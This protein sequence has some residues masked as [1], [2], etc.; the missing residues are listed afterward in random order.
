MRGS[1]GE[2]PSSSG[3]F[4]SIRPRDESVRYDNVK[5]LKLNEYGAGPFVF[6]RLSPLPMAQE[7]YEVVADGE[8]VMYIGQASDIFRTR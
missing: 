2:I 3:C 8:G 5:N 1:I 4:T 7:V 6:L